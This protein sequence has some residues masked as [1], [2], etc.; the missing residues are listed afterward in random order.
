MLSPPDAALLHNFLDDFLNYTLMKKLKKK[1]LRWLSKCYN[2]CLDN[3][4]PRKNFLSLHLL[5]ICCNDF[6][7]FCLPCSQMHQ[8]CSQLSEEEG[9]F[10][11]LSTE[12]EWAEVL[13]GAN[14]SL[15]INNPQFK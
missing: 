4:A 15:V 8:L 10:L 1:I 5:Q 2:S 13:Y 9:Y 12:Q 14:L 7:N 3:M 6:C 11:L